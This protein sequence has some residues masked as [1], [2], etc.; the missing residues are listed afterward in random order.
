MAGLWYVALENLS[1]LG[2]SATGDPDL[3]LA[4][5]HGLDYFIYANEF[6]FVHVCFMELSCLVL[7]SKMVDDGVCFLNLL[8]L[9]GPF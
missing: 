1:A 5:R 3:G 8:R 7:F 6:G 2:L 4:R 9:V